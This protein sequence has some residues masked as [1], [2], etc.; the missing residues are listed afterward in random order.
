MLPD[1]DIA[2]DRALRARRNGGRSKGPVTAEGKARAA[3]NAR[4]YGFRS[5]E[6]WLLPDEDETAFEALHDE[7]RGACAPQGETEE[8]LV[9][10][11]VRAIWKKT[12]ADRL[13]AA[14]LGDIF[15]A[16]D[17]NERLR[18]VRSLSTLVRYRN[19]ILRD[20]ERALKALLASKAERAAAARLAKQAAGPSPPPARPT[21]CT[22][23][24]SELEPVDTPRPLNRAERRRLEAL[25]RQNR[26]RAA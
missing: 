21:P 5:G 19:G 6:F 9:Q 4:R 26:R 2:Q 3:T 25:E 10:D 17:G 22:N 16:E 1:L 13:E 23:E 12:R 20:H 14:L 8:A 7:Q 18:L 11:L 24:P 15:D